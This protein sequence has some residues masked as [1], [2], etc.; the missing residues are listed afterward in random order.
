MMAPLGW[1]MV[2]MVDKGKSMLILVA[3]NQGV[4]NVSYPTDHMTILLLCAK[5]HGKQRVFVQK[6]VSIRECKSQ[7]DKCGCP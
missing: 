7:L 4:E 2:S 3:F 5:E 6:Y 1:Y